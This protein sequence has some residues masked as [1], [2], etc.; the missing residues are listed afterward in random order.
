MGRYDYLPDDE[1]KDKTKAELMLEKA[2]AMNKD[3]VPVRVDQNT[4][5]YIKPGEDPI[6]AVEKYKKVLEMH[7]KKF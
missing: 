4:T 5:I 1:S 2:K 6:A 3:R 7:R